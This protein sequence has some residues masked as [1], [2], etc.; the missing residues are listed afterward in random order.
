MD[1]LTWDIL[2]VAHRLTL[3][4]IILPLGGFK[5]VKNSEIFQIFGLYLCKAIISVKYI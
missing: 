5:N 3:S 1:F 4:V 2:C